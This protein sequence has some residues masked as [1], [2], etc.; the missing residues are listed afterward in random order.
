MQQ[1]EMRSNLLLLLT[2]AIW[3][4]A[5]VA[6]R[7]GSKYVGSFTF[8]GVRFALGGLSLVPLLIFSLRN[9]PAA[10]QQTGQRP[11]SSFR[12]GIIAGSIL[13]AGA[14]LQQI[15]LAHTAAGKAAFITGLYIILVPILGIFLKQHSHISVWIGAVLATTGLYLLS[16]TQ[17]FTITLSDLLELVGAFFWA[18]H[19]LVIDYYTKKVHAL[20]LCI[21]QF[22]TC[23]VLSM[24]AAFS[25]ETISLSSLRLALIP[26]L[27]GGLCSVGI[28]YT[29]QVF[30]QKHA[31][32]SHAAIIMSMES[33]FASLGG[34]IILQENL[35]GRGYLACI[36]ML[37]GMLISQL[38]TIFTSP[39][40]NLSRASDEE[41][42]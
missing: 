39:K 37:A 29:L 16:V 28:A 6:Q 18:T 23:S 31:K 2:A 5:F 17:N 14:S 35:G 33:V 42:L 26:I 25:F 13:F 41:S 12:A 22:L 21:I 27:Y 7:I 30:A 34:Y 1:K 20:K 19:I 4:F 10:V 9:S 24:L 15:G 8:N 3:G 40:S 32:P 38:P 36:L 11:V